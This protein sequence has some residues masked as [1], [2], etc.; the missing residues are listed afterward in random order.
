MG[1]DIGGFVQRKKRDNSWESESL[2]NTDRCY[3]N[4][5]MLANVRNHYG[6]AGTKRGEKLNYVEYEYVDNID[7][8]GVLEHEYVVYSISLPKMKDFWEKHK[9][10][11]LVTYEYDLEKG[12]QLET[13]KEVVVQYKDV[14]NLQD[15]IDQMER[16]KEFEEQEIR[17]IFEID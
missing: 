1:S 10:L 9:E 5:A 2:E 4:F 14:G 15:Y 11:P 6:F 3:G 7:R 12:R 8:G 16:F 17:M 13:Y